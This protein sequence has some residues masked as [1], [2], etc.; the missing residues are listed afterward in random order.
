MLLNQKVGIIKSLYI[1]RL[2]KPIL[3]KM[4]LKIINGQHLKHTK[5]TSQKIKIM[6]WWSLIRML[7]F[8]IFI[9]IISRRLL[10]IL[11]IV[12]TMMHLQILKKQEKWKIISAA[13]ILTTT[14]LNFRLSILHWYKIRRLLP[15]RQKILPM[16]LLITNN[17]QA[18]G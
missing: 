3:Y 17:Y 12:S 2:A 11:M 7:R 13:R 9:I 1:I 4:G 18:Q 10:K 6:C 14:G 5:N 15:S 8:S 16:P